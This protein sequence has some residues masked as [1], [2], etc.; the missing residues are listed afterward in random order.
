[1][2]VAPLEPLPFP[3]AR[4]DLRPHVVVIVRVCNEEANV[5]HIVPKTAAWRAFNCFVVIW[6]R[7]DWCLPLSGLSHEGHHRQQDGNADRA[8]Q[9]PLD[10]E[11]R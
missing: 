8:P 1:M 7:D 6:I 5:G 9:L 2:T 3:L 11:E 10:R 4:R